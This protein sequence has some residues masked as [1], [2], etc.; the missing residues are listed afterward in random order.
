MRS[1][2]GAAS[3]KLRIA[4]LAASIRDGSTSSARMEPDTSTTRITKAPSLTAANGIVGR[5]KPNA[6]AASASASSAA[7]TWRRHDGRPPAAASSTGTF[8]YLTA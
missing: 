4:S 1:A 6:S 5:A 8:V 7:G 3:T 2:L